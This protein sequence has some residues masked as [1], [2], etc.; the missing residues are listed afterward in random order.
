MIISRACILSSEALVNKLDLTVMSRKPPSALR[1]CLSVCMHHFTECLCQA[2][3][4][5]MKWIRALR[6]GSEKIEWVKSF[7]SPFS[8]LI[9]F[10]TQISLLSSNTSCV[11]QIALI[12]LFNNFLYTNPAVN[13]VFFS[14]TISVTVDY[15]SLLF[16]TLP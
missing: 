12:L 4:A 15:L 14:K 6:Y 13:I 8:F 9:L 5:V 10:L 2:G 11:Y 16:D 7:I 1:L 3:V